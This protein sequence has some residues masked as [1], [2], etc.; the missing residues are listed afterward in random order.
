MTQPQYPAAEEGF[1][2]SEERPTFRELYLA[3]FQGLH[4]QFEQYLADGDLL[5]VYYDGEDPDASVARSKHF[6]RVAYNSAIEACKLFQKVSGEQI[7]K[8]NQKVV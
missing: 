7:S 5:T 2:P 4:S 8:F 6:A 1:L 3:A